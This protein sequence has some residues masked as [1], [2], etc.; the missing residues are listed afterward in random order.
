MQN[1]YLRQETSSGRVVVVSRSAQGGLVRQ[2]ALAQTRGDLYI[3]RPGASVAQLDRASDYGSEGCRF[4]SCRMRQ[5]YT[6]RDIDY[7]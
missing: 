1:K 2:I 5:C 6:V 3:A 4:N 7:N